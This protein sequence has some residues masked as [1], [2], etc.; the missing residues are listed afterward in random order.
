MASSTDI[1]NQILGN[2]GAAAVQAQG[3]YESTRLTTEAQQAIARQQNEFNYYQA[4][5][6][7][8]T[9]KYGVD[10]NASTNRYTA[11]VGADAE[12]YASNNTLRGI[13]YGTDA[14]E[15]SSRYQADTSRYNT[16]YQADT[17]A[18]IAAGR[19]GF[20]YSKLRFSQG[21]Y[22]RLFGLVS[23]YLTGAQTG[24][25]GDPGID[26]RGVYS[27]N[28]INQQ[29]AAGR[30]QLAGQS[31][32]ASRRIQEGAAARGVSGQ[33][34]LVQMLLL[35]NAARTAGQGVD[36]E[37][38][39]RLGAAEKNA[40]QILAAQQA[41]AQAITGRFGALTGLLSSGLSAL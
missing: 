14:Q 29:V 36:T 33:S 23:P 34:P 26:V 10:A 8:Q 20:D 40:S 31:A 28:Q 35:T 13:L 3:S 7:A 17:E 4:K 12:K 19:L 6:A 30:S 21:A 1:T 16:R 18:N 25:I 37:R 15:R 2:I 24:G 9:S 27:P 22:D 32:L 39:L 38:D 41:R 5:L 11:D